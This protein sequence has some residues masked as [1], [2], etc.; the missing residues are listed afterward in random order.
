MDEDGFQ[1]M[2]EMLN[3]TDSRHFFLTA[4]NPNFKKITESRVYYVSG[5]N[6]ADILKILLI[7]MVYMIILF[8]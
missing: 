5:K 4:I 6:K 8:F 2:M 7:N 1:H 3:K